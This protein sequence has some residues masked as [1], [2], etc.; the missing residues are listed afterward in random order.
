[1]RT[2]AHPYGSWSCSS[3]AAHPTAP[4]PGCPPNRGKPRVEKAKKLFRL[5][6][7][8]A[9]ARV[10][11]KEECKVAG[12]QSY[13]GMA[14]MAAGQTERE[15]QNNEGN[16][17]LAHMKNSRDLFETINAG[18]NPLQNDG[19]FVPN[20]S[21]AATYQDATESVADAREAEINARQESRLWDSYQAELRNEQQSQ[22]AQFITP[23][24]LLTGLDPALYNDLRTVDDQTDFRNTIRTRVNALLAS[25]PNASASGTGEY[26][27][28]IISVLDA[29]IAIQQSVNELNN[30]Y[31]SIRLSEWANTQVDIINQG[32]TESLKA[33]D[34]AR[35]YANAFSISSN[36]GAATQS[37]FFS[38]ISVGFNPGS[39]ISGYLNASDRDIQTLQQAGI[40]D[41]QLQEQTRKSLLNAKRHA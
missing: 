26:G 9:T 25:Y 35:G 24:K 6:T 11:A 18:L 41:V 14:L 21:F 12:L 10:E 37:G 32:V 19:S 5:S 16:S 13:L 31:E 29:G 23:L 40:A 28:Q 36:I 22:R 20:E 34:I 8:D 15:F 4:L 2:Q 1:V 7:Q 39:I 33:H 38:S 17:L 27:A 30:L 3:F